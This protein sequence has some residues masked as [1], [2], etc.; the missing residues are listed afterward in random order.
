MVHCVPLS[1]FGM[2]VEAVALAFCVAPHGSW[3]TR[4]DAWI[5]LF[6]R[7]SERE[8]AGA[9]LVTKASP[10]SFSTRNTLGW[11]GSSSVPTFSHLRLLLPSSVVA[12]AASLAGL[13]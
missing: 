12:E 10:T 9:F 6:M 13:V 11:M 2:T 5:V 7:M 3:S 1:I 8:R 4:S